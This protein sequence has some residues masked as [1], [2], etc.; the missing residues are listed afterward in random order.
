MSRIK[1]SETTLR[2]KG[3]KA[4]MKY[5]KEAIKRPQTTWI[6]MNQLF[7]SWLNEAELELLKQQ[8]ILTKR[9][10]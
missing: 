9:L 5:Y 8:D 7:E 6:A 2:I 4:R 10:L 3:I 1:N